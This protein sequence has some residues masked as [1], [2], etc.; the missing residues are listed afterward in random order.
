MVEAGFRVIP[1]LQG[2][3]LYLPPEKLP[4]HGT[5]WSI[6]QRLEY[7]ALV[8][9]AEKG[10][11]MKLRTGPCVGHSSD[12]T[13]R[14]EMPTGS[15]ASGD[16]APQERSEKPSLP[17]CFT[18]VS[19]SGLSRHRLGELPSETLAELVLASVGPDVKQF[20]TGS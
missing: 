2:L 15:T 12:R 17:F 16:S 1:T 18:A 8:Y 7:S 6:Q 19:G 14:R 4:G 5:G 11:R 10:R 9:V 13:P 20:E 3:P